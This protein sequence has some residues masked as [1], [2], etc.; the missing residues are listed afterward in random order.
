MLVSHTPV[1]DLVEAFAR[2][3]DL[4]A[5][6]DMAYAWLDLADRDRPGRG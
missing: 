5:S 1:G 6:H 4:K 2:L 3:A